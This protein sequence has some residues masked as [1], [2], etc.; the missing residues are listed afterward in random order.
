MKKNYTSFKCQECSW[1]QT[2]KILPDATL[3][4]LEIT[5]HLFIILSLVKCRFQNH[6]SD[7]KHNAKVQ[8][9]N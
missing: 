6:W 1:I 9:V 7:G 8:T 2:C 5:M 4:M 3:I